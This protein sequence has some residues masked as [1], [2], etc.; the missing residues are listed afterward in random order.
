[1]NATAALLARL[2]RARLAREGAAVT[3][4]VAVSSLA[5][6]LGMRLLTELTAPALFGGFALV[7]GL[8]MLLVA[9]VFSPLAQAAFRFWPQRERDGDLPAFRAL[10]AG[11][12]RRRLLLAGGC[13]ALAASL[14]QLGRGWL[15][16]AVWA[17]VLAG[18]AVDV[19]RTR[20]LTEFNAAHRQGA[21]AALTALDAIARPVGAAALLWLAGPSLES[22]LAGQ[23]LGA[24]IVAAGFWRRLPAAD[25]RLQRPGA[26]GPQRRAFLAYALPLSGVAIV[27]WAIGMADRYV[28]GGIVGLAAAGSYAAAYALGSR[29]L[30]L[31]GSITDS[32]L[33]QRL[34]AAA[35]AEDAGAVRRSLLLWLGIN[36]GVGLA[37]AALVT[38][39]SGLLVFLFL[40]EAFRDVA[41][42]LIPWI[43]FGHVFLLG[44]QVLERMLFA[45]DRTGLFLAVQ[46][47][48]ALFGI[49]AA[50]AGA[51]WAGVEGVAMAVP[52]TFGFQLAL[53]LLAATWIWRRPIGSAAWP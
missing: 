32:T 28:V 10:L 48:T 39:L 26:A 34:Y 1:M 11:E 4:G 22:L 19:A 33:R 47:T 9:A 29:P 50:V 41:A 31:V 7:N 6:L 14:D 12:F 24:A 53:T 44:A 2:G 17:L 36:L 40:G 20:A 27:G 13:I 46:T 23:A 49:A 5:T 15:S 25:T 3:V 43:A 52:L 42:R 8:V 16:P 38:L 30:L 18:V 37:G 21:F 35:T 45:R 51:H